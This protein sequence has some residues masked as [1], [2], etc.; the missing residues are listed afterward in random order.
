[1]LLVA[2]TPPEGDQ[3]DDRNTVPESG[4]GASERQNGKSAV[5][6]DQGQRATCHDHAAQRIFAPH[7]ANHVRLGESDDSSHVP[8]IRLE[9]LRLR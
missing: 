2:Y 1:M 7:P 9:T 5:R 6:H 8:E 3:R 4:V